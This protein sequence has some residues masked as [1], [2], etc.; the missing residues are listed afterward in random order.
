[1][2]NYMVVFTDK[3]YEIVEAYAC[4]SEGKGKYIFDIGHKKTLKFKDVAS[5]KDLGYVS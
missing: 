1:M 5:V 3:S 4:H 2:K